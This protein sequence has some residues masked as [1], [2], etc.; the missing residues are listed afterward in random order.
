MPVVG[1]IFDAADESKCRTLCNEDGSCSGCGECCSDFLP[2][3]NEEII[4]IQNYLKKHPM[5]P[6][7]NL[8]APLRTKMADM[9]CPFRN[10]V[11]KKCD[12]YEIRPL[13]CRNFICTKTL[14]DGK[15]DREIVSKKRNVYSMRKVFFGDSS[16]EAMLRDISFMI[17][18][19]FARS[20][21]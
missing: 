16:N 8:L 3:S 20:G 18:E 5:E 21:F 2:L 7:R 1:N 12:I 14:E 4:R 13:I 11:K 10:N 6:H 19:S 9:T 15:K 17:A